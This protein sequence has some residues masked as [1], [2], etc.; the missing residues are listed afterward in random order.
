MKKIIPYCKQV[1]STTLLKN[2]VNK[3]HPSKFLLKGQVKV[4]H[5]SI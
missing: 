4:G 2:D 3:Q 1:K 5:F